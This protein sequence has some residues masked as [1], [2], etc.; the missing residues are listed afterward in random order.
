MAPMHV[1]DY[2]KF[3]YLETALD[4]VNAL[5]PWS[6][7]L[8]DRQPDSWLFR[9]HQQK[10]WA[11]LPA[12]LRSEESLYA[13]T[14]RR[15]ESN[16]QQIETELDILLAFFE[17]SNLSGLHLPEDSQRLRNQLEHLRRVVV[18]GSYFDR[19]EEGK[20]Q[21]PP[22]ELLSLAGLAQHYGLPTRLLD[23][24]YNG[25]VAAYFA[26][27]GV[28]NKAKAARSSKRLIED[29]CR[30]KGLQFDG[31][32]ANL[33]I[34]GGDRSFAVWAYDTSLDLAVEFSL[35]KERP[36]RLVTVPYAGNPNIQAQKGLFTVTV[37][38]SIV[39]DGQID[40]TPFDRILAE[41]FEGDRLD[42]SKH[43]LITCFHT[44]HDQAFDV[45]RLL[46]GVGINAATVFPGYGGA[47]HAVGEK[48]WW[49]AKQD[50]GL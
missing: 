44:S 7:Y 49:W 23:W 27:S 34:M 20:D 6:A 43:E 36:Y 28:V 15:C 33:S 4:F 21:W 41:F 1:K 8:G 48:L 25:Y 5:S 3:V 2:V 31:R 14:S 38:P 16:R 19:L 35:E 37:C 29:Y 13:E 24:T 18:A 40:R 17:V 26:A 46:A 9:G 11:L 50:Q 47:R 45:L 12:A 42:P 22:D 30:R 39:A 10:E 32:A